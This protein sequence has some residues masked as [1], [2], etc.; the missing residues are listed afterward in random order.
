MNGGFGNFELVGE[1][2]FGLGQDP[3][4]FTQDSSNGAVLETLLLLH[5]EDKG[6]GVVFGPDGFPVFLECA[7]SVNGASLMAAF[8]QGLEGSEEFG[9]FPVP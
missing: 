1:E 9:V 5:P 4:A 7:V 8:C 6:M 2:G 3:A